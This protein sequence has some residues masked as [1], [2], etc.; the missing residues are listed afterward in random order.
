[1]L[2]LRRAL[3]TYGFAASSAGEAT[4]CRHQQARPLARIPSPCACG[5]GMSQC[6]LRRMTSLLLGP[7]RIRFDFLHVTVSAQASLQSAAPPH[8]CPPCATAP[9]PPY[10]CAFVWPAPYSPPAP[11]LT[12]PPPLHPFHE[13]EPRRVL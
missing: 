8:R 12:C 6:L 3:P 1:M 9:A 7:S 13:D 5:C 11:A 4:G 10:A 2:V